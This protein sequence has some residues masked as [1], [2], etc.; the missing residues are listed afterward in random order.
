MTLEQPGTYAP[1]CAYSDG[2]KGCQTNTDGRFRVALNDGSRGIGEVESTGAQPP[3]WSKNTLTHRELGG[4]AREM[5]LE[6]NLQR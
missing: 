6:K 3:C 4:R 5:L 1:E 2:G